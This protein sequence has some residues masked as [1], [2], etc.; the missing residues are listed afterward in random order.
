MNTILATFLDPWVLFGFA[1]QGVFFTR[2]L[3]Q[4]IASERAGEIRVPVAFW[5]LSIIGAVMIFVYAMRQ[6]DIVFIFGQALALVMYVRNLMI[7][8]K[9][10]A[11]NKNNN[12]N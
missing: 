7:Y 5:Y 2:F 1:A 12:D 10:P 8:Y 9:S 3:V 11:V 4:W 6:Q